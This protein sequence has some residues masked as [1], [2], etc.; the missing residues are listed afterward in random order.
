MAV[1]NR[2]K[3]SLRIYSGSGNVALAAA[4]AH[5][6][7]VPLSPTGVARFSDGET[8]I[9]VAEPKA[10]RAATVIV[11][12]SAIPAG[13]EKLMEALLL[14]DAIKR[15]QPQRLIAVFPFFPYRRQQRQTEAGEPVSAE[16][17]ARL[18]EAAGATSVLLVDPHSTRTLDLFRIPVRSVTALNLFAEHWQQMH[19]PKPLVVAEDRGAVPRAQWVAALLEADSI[20]L[21]KER[22]SHDT[23]EKLSMNPLHATRVAGA[24]CFIVDD[25]ISTAGTLQRAVETLAAAGAREVHVAVTHAVLSGPAIERLSVLSLSSIVVTDSIALGVEKRLRNMTVLPIA[26]LIVSSLKE[27]IG[28]RRSSNG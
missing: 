21:E 5:G 28:S 11:I 14:L 15:H 4:V 7:G 26:P 2:R 13:N 8:Y 12:Q 20:L 25:E 10:I 9:N 27:M 19:L 16:L 24:T 18:I 23:V 3:K 17:V 6:L 22:L 1:R